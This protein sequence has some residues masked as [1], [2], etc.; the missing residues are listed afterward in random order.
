MRQFIVLG[1]KT[2]SKTAV[3]ESLY[4]GA[5]NSA[6]IAVVN[7]ASDGFARKELYDLT[8]PRIRRHSAPLDPEGTSLAMAPAVNQSLP[9]RELPHLSK[10]AQQLADQRGLTLD[11]L[12]EVIPTGSTGNIVQDDIEKLL[13]D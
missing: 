8:V 12:A 13:E 2:P 5:D 9:L 7:A 4:L 3:G 6:A 11:Q 1:F 10:G